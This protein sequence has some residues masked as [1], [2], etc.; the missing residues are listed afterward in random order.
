MWCSGRTIPGYY[1]R[2][3]AVRS[4]GLVL[5]IGAYLLVSS[6]CITFCESI[7]SEQPHGVLA[8]I[9]RRPWVANVGVLVLIVIVDML[10]Q[11]SPDITLIKRVKQ[12]EQKICPACL[13]DLQKLSVSGVCP[14]CG[15]PYTHDEC[16][17]VWSSYLS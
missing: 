15:K 7:M 16:R 9:C 2:R 3:R 4:A 10:F 6:Y 13:Y 14:E 1:R 8:W 12:S 11:S 5:S 17:R